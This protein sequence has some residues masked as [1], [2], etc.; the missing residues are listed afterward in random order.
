MDSSALTACC[1]VLE[2]EHLI[3]E[4]FINTKLTHSQTLMP[5]VESLLENTKTSL[6][7]ID[8]FAISQGPG[9]FTGLRIGLSAIKG[10]AFATNKPCIGVSTLQAM[11]YNLISSSGTVCAVMNA[12][13]DQVYTATYKIDNF[14]IPVYEDKAISIDE[15]GCA[16]EKIDDTI[17]L[18]GDGAEMCYERLKFK[19]KDLRLTRETDRY[20]KAYSVGLAAI[21]K[22]KTDGSIL[23]AELNPIYLRLPQAERE[24][25]EKR[26]VSL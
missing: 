8:L 4:F 19:I 20:A 7:T 15:L 26:G 14:N 23:P 11:C 17:Y 18:V 21:A 13:R 3:G 6:S 16:L 5:M 1:A 10:L 12:R 24:L 25:L 22:Y 9:S 2:D